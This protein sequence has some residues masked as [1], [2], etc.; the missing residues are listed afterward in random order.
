MLVNIS[1]VFRISVII[2][3]KVV[4]IY[5]SDKWCIWMSD[6]KNYSTSTICQAKRRSRQ[7]LM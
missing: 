4:D 2:E 6:L 3:N 1:G 7:F 5:N